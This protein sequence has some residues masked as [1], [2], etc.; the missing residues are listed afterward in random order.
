MEPNAKQTLMNDL[1]PKWW[2]HYMNGETTDDESTGD[3]T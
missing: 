2:L 1:I 3:E